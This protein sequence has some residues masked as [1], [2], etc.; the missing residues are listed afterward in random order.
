MVEL[1]LDIKKQDIQAFNDVLDEDRAKAIAIQNKKKAFGMLSVFDNAEN[2]QLSHIEK[3][4]EPFWH[5]IGESYIDYLRKNNYGFGVDP[6]VRSVKIA[7][8][9]FDINGEQPYCGFEAEDHCIE[10]Y[11]KEL[12]TDAVEG[13]QPDKEL[14]KYLEFATR[15]IKETEELMGTNKIVVP[16]KIKAAYLIR[17]FVK[18]LIKPVHADKIL[19]ETIEI[20]KAVL[21]FR[22]IHAFEFT[23]KKSNKTGVIEVDALTGEVAKGRVYKSGLKELIP[24]GALFDIGTE[25]ASM[26]IPGAGFG[27][28]VGK[29]IKERRDNNKAKKAMKHSQDAMAERKKK[30]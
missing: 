24:E 28:V 15:S 22:P 25:L 12:L 10:K 1:K 4:Y 23:N 5:I 16:A 6:Q 21:Y 17:D 30:R 27:A 11:T 7:N 18:E 3:R 19:N 20:K 9:I 14:R 29:A 13:K 8:T 2:M 26:V